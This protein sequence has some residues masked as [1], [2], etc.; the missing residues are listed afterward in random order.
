M[1]SE[2][3]KVIGI[4]SQKEAC[5]WGIKRVSVLWMGGIEGV[6]E[7]LRGNKE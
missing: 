7:K 4:C 1:F 3:E 5:L 2:L 6:L